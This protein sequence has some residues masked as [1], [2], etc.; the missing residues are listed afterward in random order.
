M[1]RIFNY[2]TTAMGVG[3]PLPQNFF[4]R[5]VKISQVTPVVAREGAPNPRT[6][7]MATPLSPVT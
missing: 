1:A 4:I 6:L 3:N 5:F 7:W 2:A